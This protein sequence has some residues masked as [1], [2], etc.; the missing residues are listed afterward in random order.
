VQFFVLDT[1]RIAGEAPFQPE[2]IAWIEQ[3]LQRSTATWKVVYGHHPVFSYGMHGDQEAM[4]DYV[5]PLLEKYD[6]TAYICG[7]D[8]DRQFLGPVNGVYY[9]VSGTGAKSRHTQYGKKTVFAATNL[10]FT[11]FR[12]SAEDFHVQFLDGDGKIEFAH[13]WTKSSAVKHLTEELS[14]IAHHAGKSK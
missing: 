12:V 11:W 13:T 10:G 8:H 4:I 5:R 6:V 14:D 1:E 7:H 2:Q 9:I 3:E